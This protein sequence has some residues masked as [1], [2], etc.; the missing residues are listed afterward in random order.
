MHQ[1]D[2]GLA[3]GRCRTDAPIPFHELTVRL[4]VDDRREIGRALAVLVANAAFLDDI[5]GALACR[6]CGGIVR[7]VVDI[8]TARRAIGRRSRRRTRPGGK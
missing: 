2:D 8:G 1:H 4:P 5:A 6:R 3:F 7:V